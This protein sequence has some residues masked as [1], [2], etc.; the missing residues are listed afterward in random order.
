M[1]VLRIKDLVNRGPFGR[2]KLFA[3]IAA[4]RLVARKIGRSTVVHE[5][6]WR[7]YLEGTPRAAKA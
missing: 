5:S 2:T 6:D 1:T 4:G 3:D 7:A